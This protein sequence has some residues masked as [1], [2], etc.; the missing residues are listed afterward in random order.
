ML[1][2]AVQIGPKAALP[3]NRLPLVEDDEELEELDEPG[4][5][6]ATIDE[7]TRRAMDRVRQAE[8]ALLSHLHAVESEA[9]HRSE[10]VIAQ[11]ELDAELIRLQARRTAHGI[12]AEASGQANEQT[13]RERRSFD[14]LSR[15]LSRFAAVLDDVS[16]TART[17][18][19][20]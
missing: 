16:A 6:P 10:L 2:D 5:T 19:S 3:E 4:S 20:G 11:A 18:T 9:A 17:A 14:E 8:E 15:S 12:L 13:A 1:V 7:V